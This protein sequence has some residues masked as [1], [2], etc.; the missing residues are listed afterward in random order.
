MDRKS[1]WKV[2]I[3]SLVGSLVVYAIVAYAGGLKAADAKTASCSK[4][5]V[6]VVSESS[7]DVMDKSAT[8]PEGWEPFSMVGFGVAVRQCAN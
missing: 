1:L 8:M 3:G 5:K 6:I 4:W 2:V 7:S